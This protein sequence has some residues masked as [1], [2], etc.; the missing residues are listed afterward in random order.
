MGA[1]RRVE[2]D[3]ELY[4]RAS[5]PRTTLTAP[6][7]KSQSCSVP[8]GGAEDRPPRIGPILGVPAS[9][10]HRV[11]T[12]HGLN[13]LRY[14]PAGQVICRYERAS[15]GELVQVDVK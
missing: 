4:D 10:V 6:R 7:Q 1:P 8:C 9:T 15:P 2:G 12:R 3:A 11:L 14:R 13:R 5:R